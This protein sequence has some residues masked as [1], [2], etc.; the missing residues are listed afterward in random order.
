MTSNRVFIYKEQKK[1]FDVDE[2]EEDLKGVNGYEKV[3]ERMK[4][5]SEIYYEQCLFDW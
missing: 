5:M 3:W 2:F 4:K 1:V